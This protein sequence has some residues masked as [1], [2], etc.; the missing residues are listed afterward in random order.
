MIPADPRF[1]AWRLGDLA[2]DAS[3]AEQEQLLDAMIEAY[4]A[5]VHTPIDPGNDEGPFWAVAPL[6][7]EPRLRAAIALV[8]QMEAERWVYGLGGT[9]AALLGQ[10]AALGFVEEALAGITRIDRCDPFAVH[11]LAEAYGRI[12]AVWD[13]PVTE[14]LAVVTVDL[15]D[16]DVRYRLLSALV[17]V[18]NPLPADELQDW[19]AFAEATADPRMRALCL[20]L[21][22]D[23]E[24]TRTA[25][26][27][28]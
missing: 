16:P 19:T 24:Q 14:R 6:L 4:A 21:L 18:D 20:E 26:P 12:L 3:G 28:A 7:D 2:R 25:S 9:W 15:Q 11:W 27:P 22:E 10:L 1:E 5:I 8:E 23:D 13:A 17:W